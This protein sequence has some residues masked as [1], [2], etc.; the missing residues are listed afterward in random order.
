MLVKDL[1]NRLNQIVE[2]NPNNNN[3]EI[4]WYD[5]FERH[6]SKGEGCPIRLFQNIYNGN[7]YCVLNAVDN[8]PAY[9]LKAIS[10]K[11]IPVIN[12]SIK[13]KG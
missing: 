5:Q 4:R 12:N 2:T 10:D 8:P 6:I 9:G 11:G 3:L 7:I 13:R 1:I